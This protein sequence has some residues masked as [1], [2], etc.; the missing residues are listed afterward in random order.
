M[1]R[2]SADRTPSTVAIV[3]VSGLAVGL[4]AAAVNT[5]GYL[6]P[7][8]RDDLD[9]GRGLIGAVSSTFFA[10]TG[11]A[12]FLLPWLAVRLGTRR[13]LVATLALIAGG[14]A[15]AAGVGALLTLFVYAALAGV[16]YSLITITTNS[17]VGAAMPLRRRASG[18]TAKTAGGPVVSSC[19][20]LAAGALAPTIG[21]R[22]VLGILGGFALLAAALSLRTFGDRRP[23]I[24]T[25]ALGGDGRGSG[26]GSAV[27]L[28]AASGFFLD[29]GALPTFAWLVE[30]LRDEVG[31]SSG[32]AGVVTAVSTASGVVGMMAVA[33]LSDRLGPDRRLSLLTATLLFTALACLVMLTATEDRLAPI[34]AAAIVAIVMFTGAVGLLHAAIVDLAPDSVEQA[35]GI[36]M[37]GFYLGGLLSPL[38]FGLLVDAS[39]YDLAW[40]VSA[41]VLGAGTVTSGLATWLGAR[42]VPT[43]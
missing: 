11:V 27:L 26:L 39:G 21:W 23:E 30:F 41:A 38:G 29:A 6:T 35:T 31:L 10:A 2:A 25:P 18:L 42:R 36:V 33:V 8:I 1:S 40:G 13:T 19:F 7:F 37:T 32:G 34:F 20:A 24:A 15:L 4:G 28:L 43:V 5:V 14:V 9:I 16:S 17:A 12:S 22:G 3:G